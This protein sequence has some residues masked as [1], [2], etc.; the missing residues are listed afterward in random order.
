MR[1]SRVRTAPSAASAPAGRPDRR[2]TVR[3]AALAGRGP[4]ALLAL[5]ADVRQADVGRAHHASSAC[6]GRDGRRARRRGGD[7]VDGQAAAA[8]S[9]SG[10]ERWMAAKLVEPHHVVGDDHLG[11]DL[12]DAPAGVVDRR[13]RVLQRVLVESRPARPVV[14][15][16]GGAAAVL[17]DSSGTCATLPTTTEAKWGRPPPGHRSSVGECVRVERH[18]WQCRR[19]QRSLSATVRWLRETPRRAT[20]DTTPGG[21]THCAGVNSHSRAAT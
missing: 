15:A 7:G 2:R 11:R 10:A 12:G 1:A 20:E 9:G 14:A 6:R 17:V 5:D 21:T 3:R 8:R 19:S 18:G 4:P 16:R 13:G